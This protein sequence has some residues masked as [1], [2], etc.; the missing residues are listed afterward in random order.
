MHLVF[1][2]RLGRRYLFLNVEDAGNINISLMAYR[3]GNELA[4]LSGL[5]GIRIDD[6]THLFAL[7][8]LFRELRRTAS[9]KVEE[10]EVER[11]W[12]FE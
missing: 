9:D 3:S 7:A 2:N 6:L 11:L 1:P 10:V 4:K 12:Y 8:V 5:P